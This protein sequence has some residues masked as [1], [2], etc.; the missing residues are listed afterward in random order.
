VCHREVRWALSRKRVPS[1]SFGITK[2]RICQFGNGLRSCP[3][4]KVTRKGAHLLHS[5]TG[6]GWRAHFDELRSLVHWGGP[7]YPRIVADGSVALEINP[8]AEVD[9]DAQGGF[10][11]LE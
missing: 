7:S 2:M 3:N 8:R 5:E 1:L 4:T 9:C 6:P 10:I 11:S